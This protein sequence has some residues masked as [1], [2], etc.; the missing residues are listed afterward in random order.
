MHDGKIVGFRVP[1][2]KKIN[3]IK[4]ENNR[5]QDRTRFDSL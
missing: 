4:E 3:W 1:E 2:A 5:K